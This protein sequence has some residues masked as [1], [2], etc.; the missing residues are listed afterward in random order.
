MLV[1][2]ALQPYLTVMTASSKILWA[3]FLP[4]PVP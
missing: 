1:I 4:A 3:S 2:M